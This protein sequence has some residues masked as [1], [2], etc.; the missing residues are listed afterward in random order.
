MATL[1]RQTAE[2]LELLVA[3]YPV[4]AEGKPL[5]IGTF[6]QLVQR[7]PEIE[8]RILRT[9]L[10]RYCRRPRYLKAIAA[11]RERYDL[12]GQ[13]VGE[14]TET[15]REKAKSGL[16]SCEEREQ[17]AKQRR[18]EQHRGQRRQKKKPSSAR[19]RG[20]L[21]R[22]QNKRNRPNRPRRRC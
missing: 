15:Q 4:F 6:D 18:R 14:I 5:A 8:F 11:G 19:R 21:L 2:T 13:P 3:R 9:T 1:D 20:R 16:K 17:A 7:H 10:I 12:D 22:G